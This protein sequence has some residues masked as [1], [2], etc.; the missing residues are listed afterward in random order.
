MTKTNFVSIIN[1]EVLSL[2][3]I[4]TSGQKAAWC[5]L[6]YIRLCM[7]WTPKKKSEPTDSYIH[8]LFIYIHERNV[9]GLEF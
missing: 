7:A 9:T 2:L 8:V 3:W 4:K 1:W 6:W 5:I